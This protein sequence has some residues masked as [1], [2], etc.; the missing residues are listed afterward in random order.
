MNIEKAIIQRKFK[1]EFEKLAVNIHY[2]E[3]WLRGKEF[4]VFKKY[5]LS[6]QQFN[7]LRILNGRY[8]EVAS[9]QLIKER[10]IDKDSNASRL[11]D[12]LFNSDLLERVQC[13][14]DRRM[15]EIKITEKG[16]E[17]LK[18]V[19]PEIQQAQCEYLKLSEQEATQLN[20]LLDKLR[21]S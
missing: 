9:V 8:P 12:K 16:R 7:V 19:I 18:T 11:I 20:D 13:P 14:N 3:S 10:M 4:Q 5:G 6:M 17:L 2:T 1:S 15:V 21:M